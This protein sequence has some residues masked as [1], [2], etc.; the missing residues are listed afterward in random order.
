[1]NMLGMFNCCE[2]LENLDISNFD[3]NKVSI[4]AY[5]FADCKNL[6]DLDLSNFSISYLKPENC[7][8]MF[9]GCTYYKNFSLCHFATI[10]E[11]IL[12]GNEE[13]NQENILY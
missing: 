3:T 7:K 11:S 5:M 4:L 12:L 8:N 6:L 1:M 2:S 10:D 13:N 9:A